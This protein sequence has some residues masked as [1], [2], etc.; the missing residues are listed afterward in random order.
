[1]LLEAS[2]WMPFLSGLPSQNEQITLKML[3]W[4]FVTPHMAC[5]VVVAYEKCCVGLYTSFLFLLSNALGNICSRYPSIVVIR[6][7]IPFY[8]VTIAGRYLFR[9]VQLRICS[10]SLASLYP[11]SLLGILTAH[12]LC[13]TMLYQLVKYPPSST[14]AAAEALCQ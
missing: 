1:M 8:C 5:D 13:T 4:N 7:I 12:Q 6:Y 2:R 3:V 11:L 14:C 9:I 10:K